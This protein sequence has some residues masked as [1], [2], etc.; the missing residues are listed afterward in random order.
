ML[1]E[2]KHD[3]WSVEVNGKKPHFTIKE[4]NSIIKEF[5]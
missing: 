3:G 4:D 2:N 1:D 5:I